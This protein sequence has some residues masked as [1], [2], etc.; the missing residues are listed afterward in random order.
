MGG[1]ELL[2]EFQEP[3][4]LGGRLWPLRPRVGG[5][6]LL[7]SWLRRVAATYGI[8]PRTF[9]TK[10][11]CGHSFDDADLEMPAAG[12]AFL[13]RV[14]RCALPEGPG[15]AFPELAGAMLVPP[16][17]YLIARDD[18]NVQAALAR[19]DGMLLRDPERGRSPVL[20]FCPRCLAE[21]P[22]PVFRKDWRLAHVC[23]CPDHGVRLHDRCPGCGARVDLLS[24]RKAVHE[25]QCH[26]CAY[27]L[28]LAP[29]T[30][31]AMLTLITQKRLAAL[32]DFMVNRG[33]PG[34]DWERLVSRV[35]TLPVRTR[36][37]AHVRDLG[38]LSGGLR[39]RLFADLDTER[40]VA[41]VVGPGTRAQDRWH[42]AIL[43]GHKPE[44][45]D[46]YNRKATRDVGRRPKGPEMG[47]LMEDFDASSKHG[48]RGTGVPRGV[49]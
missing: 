17:G 27:V 31:A 32:F 3:L 48:R 10:V 33:A 21:Y 24:G 15:H 16:A 47:E 7:S 9:R 28:R 1:A 36:F 6:E 19:T 25:P 42:R 12:L 43:R 30:P 13:A 37:S 35:R 5:D 11:P 40:L 49:P 26:R 29:V 38:R 8:A 34:K 44:A 18:H 46:G 22:D 41:A 4:R 39:A 2:I 14:Y 23:A 20:Q 45:L